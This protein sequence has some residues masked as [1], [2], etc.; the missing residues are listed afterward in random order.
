VHGDRGS[1]G[2]HRGGGSDLSG[3]RRRS[4]PLVP[5]PPE[6]VPN[7]L[8][9]AFFLGGGGTHG[10]GGPRRLHR[11]LQP[12]PWKTTKP[13]PPCTSTPTQK[14]RPLDITWSVTVLRTHPQHG[15]HHRRED[16]AISCTNLYTISWP[17]SSY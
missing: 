12:P 16:A 15:R 9:Q 2:L 5:P 4:P 13:L 1:D 10:G 6:I 8:F 7:L 14:A 17:L 11:L 3:R